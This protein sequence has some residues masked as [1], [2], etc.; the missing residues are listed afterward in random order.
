MSNLD[1]PR[2]RPGRER[3]LSLLELLAGLV[4]GMLVMMSALATLL[5][6][7][8][9]AGAVADLS[10]LQQ[11]GAYALHVI[12]L[13]FRQAGAVELMRNEVTGR[14]A[15]GPSRAQAAGTDFAVFGVDG[16]GAAPDKVSVAFAAAA[17]AKAPGQ[18][19]CS[20]SGVSG[21]ERVD[22]TFE[23]DA[24]GQLSC[25]GRRKQPLVSGVA[26]FQVRYR[27]ATSDGVQIMAAREVEALKR[28]GAVA[29]IE[30]CLDLQGSEKSPQAGQVYRGCDGDRPS[31]GRAHLVSR[32]VFSVRPQ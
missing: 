5:L 11:Q 15:F 12:G 32:N 1:R 28:W 23:V 7:R 20:G 19:D 24:K 9:A 31:N 25:T 18:Y 17:W 26:D 4:V 21:G 10:Q 29:A 6:S 8:E 14:Y 22:A 2:P 30:I 16:K 13:Q 3:G 27:V